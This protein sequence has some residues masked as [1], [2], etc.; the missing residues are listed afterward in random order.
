MSN[1][2]TAEKTRVEEAAGMVQSCD[3]ELSNGA[4]FGSPSQKKRARDNN[5]AFA[6]TRVYLATNTTT[7]RALTL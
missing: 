2:E 5:R 7:L 3:A 4:H 6:D 1:R